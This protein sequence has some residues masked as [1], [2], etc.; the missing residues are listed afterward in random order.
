LKSSNLLVRSALTINHL[1]QNINL[2][3][4]NYLSTVARYNESIIREHRTLHLLRVYRVH[5]HSIVHWPVSILT[6][7]NQSSR[8]F[9]ALHQTKLHTRNP[10][11]AKAERRTSSIRLQ[12][13]CWTL[14][15][16]ILH[17]LHTR[18]LPRQSSRH[19]ADTSL[20]PYIHGV[21]AIL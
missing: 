8:P 2:F 19:V 15:P 21:L 5:L 7:A 16:N 3:I 11:R 4:N 6:V 20:S 12:N 18:P 9:P 14:P 13:T 17:I 10:A 1:F